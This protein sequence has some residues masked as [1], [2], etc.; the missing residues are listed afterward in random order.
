MSCAIA[1][2][3]MNAVDNEHMVE[4]AKNVGEYLLS[5]LK[6]MQKE[7]PEVIGDVRGVGLFVGIELV[8]DQKTKAPATEETKNVVDRQSYDGY[9]RCSNIY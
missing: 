4:N 1:L 6:T 7:F 8:K 9:K 2:A 5:E 3:V